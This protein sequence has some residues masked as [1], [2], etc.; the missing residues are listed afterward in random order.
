M[1]VAIDGNFGL[2]HKK[3]SGRSLEPPK[4]MGRLF[5][6]TEE[7]QQAIDS[8][9]NDSKVDDGVR[10]VANSDSKCWRT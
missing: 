3:S 9:C 2:V 4:H 5:I 7:V 10:T 6:P 8:S 1:T